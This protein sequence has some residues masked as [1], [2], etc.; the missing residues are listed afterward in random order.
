MST[1]LWC[2]LQTLFWLHFIGAVNHSFRTKWYGCWDLVFSSK[3]QLQNAMRVSSHI[4]IFI[5]FQNWQPN[6]LQNGIEMLT[7]NV[8]AGRKMYELQPGTLFL[9]TDSAMV[10]SPIS[11]LQAVECK[12]GLAKNTQCIFNLICKICIFKILNGDRP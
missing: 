7:N 1:R 5:N 6:T 12:S 3:S 9:F 10:S 4:T 8:S 11:R 2:R